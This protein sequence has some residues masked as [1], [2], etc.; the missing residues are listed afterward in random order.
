MDNV[1]YLSLS[2]AAMI[3]RANSVTTNNIANANTKGFRAA[4]SVFDEMV[5]KTDMDGPL[6]EMSYAL[7]RGTYTSTDE[8][9]FIETGNALDVA[10]QGDGWFS[11]QMP[12][13]NTA[14]GRDGSFIRSN[15]GELQTAAGHPVLDIGGAPIVIPPEAVNLSISADGTISTPEG[16]V[17]AQIGIFEAQ[18]APTWSRNP[19]GML[20]VPE[21]S[22]PLMPALQANVLQ[23]FSEQ[24]NVNPIV[25]M[26]R[27]IGLQRAYERSMNLANSADELR[28]DTIKRLGKA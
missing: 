5:V 1:S 14:I 12:D 6:D 27:M 28:S 3:E 22:L 19:G 10:I 4:R 11:Y 20:E 8:G 24:S 9:A 18:D 26:T 25:E 2:R 23:G 17:V 7:D 16:D 15:L 13:G 21:G